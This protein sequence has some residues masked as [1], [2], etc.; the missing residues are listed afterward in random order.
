MPTSDTPV[1]VLGLGLIGGSVLRALTRA[2]RATYGWN[3]S[4]A[5]V[6]AA[7][8]DGFDTSSD[9][10]ATLARADEGHVVLVAVP[11][12][13]LDSV[14]ASVADH[15]PHAWLTDAVS[16]KAHVAKRVAAAGLTSRY[17][18]GHPMA[19]TAQ[20]GWSATDAELFDGAT[21]V[22]VADDATPARAWLE[23]ASVGLDCGAAVV[24]AG[25]AEHDAAVARISH[26]VHMVAEA[27]AVTAEADPA[28]SRLALSLA[29]SSFRDVTRV[30]G[31]PP[32]LVRAMCESNRDALLHALDDTIAELSAV[33]GELA[34]HGTVAGLVE[35]GHS[36]RRDYDAVT[37]TPFTPALDGAG[38]Q[39]A[40]REAG[41][42]GGV[43]T[44][45]P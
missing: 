21:W 27:A 23:A 39:R 37:R 11:V 6:D 25:S 35:R 2:G 42:A 28:A 40:L 22:V 29:A 9:L 4:Q 26:S 18:G 14:L 13:A 19:G 16:V 5:G 15:A 12:P 41:H 1:C 3:R 10:A 24:P 17:A 33:R 34:E 38:W 45:L 8:A 32:S 44:E 20:S 7:A 30:A 43:V 31:T 36:A